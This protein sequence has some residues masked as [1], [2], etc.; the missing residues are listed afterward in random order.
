[1]SYQ[2]YL[3]EI[4]GVTM[5]SPMRREDYYKKFMPKFSIKESYDQYVRLESMSDKQ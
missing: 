3:D 1:M 4:I 5:N 2:E